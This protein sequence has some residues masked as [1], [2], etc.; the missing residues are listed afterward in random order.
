MCAGRRGPA[1]ASSFVVA[2]R[3]GRTAFTLIELLVVGGIIALLVAILTPSWLA[4]REAGR[5]TVCLS[6]LKQI[7]HAIQMYTQ[8]NGSYLPGPT[9]LLLFRSNGDLSSLGPYGVAWTRSS[10]PF[11]LAP[12]LSGVGKG[13]STIDAVTVCPSADGVPLT[14][15]TGVLPMPLANQR[16][17]YVANTGGIERGICRPNEKPWYA[18]NP[19][20][21]F[22][23]LHYRDVPELWP[24]YE[25]KR[26]MPKSILR[27]ANQSAEWAVADLWHWE[28]RAAVE[29]MRN[30]GTWPFP[31]T[32][33][34][35][36]SFCGSPRFPMPCQPF[37]NTPRRFSPQSTDRQLG[38]PR[39]LSGQTNAL[40][41][42]GHAAPVRD[43]KGTVNP[44]FQFDIN[45]GDCSGGL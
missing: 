18:T 20:N 23:Y 41:L 2:P 37:H 5:S 40:Y 22:G 7:G 39:L 28:A 17:Y 45:C 27:I 8:D 12:Y 38:S 9:S 6:N 43:W 32:T 1:R 25:K 10:L 42:D 19:V 13:A 36:P 16:C 15:V 21:Y 11:V 33:V 44:C 35:S 31:V 14:S 24:E 29:P 4:A 26:R 3:R 30:V 34:G